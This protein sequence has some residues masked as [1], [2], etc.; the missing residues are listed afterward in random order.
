LQHHTDG[1]EEMETE[2]TGEATTSANAQAGD[3]GHANPKSHA[4]AWSSFAREGPLHNATY[5]KI[6]TFS[7]TVKNGSCVMAIRENLCSEWI[8]CMLSQLNYRFNK[9]RTMQKDELTKKGYKI[10]KIEGK[11]KFLFDL[12]TWMKGDG[13]KTVYVRP[14]QGKG[15]NCNLP[16]PVLPMADRLSPSAK[17]SHQTVEQFCIERYGMQ[18]DEYSEIV[19]GKV[20]RPVEAARFDFELAIFAFSRIYDQTRVSL[21]CP[22]EP[23]KS[24]WKIWDFERSKPGV[25]KVHLTFGNLGDR[26]Y[27]SLVDGADKHAYDGNADDDAI[28]LDTGV[29]ATGYEFEKCEVCQKIRLFPGKAVKQCQNSNM[30]FEG[31]PSGRNNNDGCKDAAILSMIRDFFSSPISRGQNAREKTDYILEFNDVQS[32]SDDENQ[33]KRVLNLTY[34]FFAI[35]AV[36]S[37]QVLQENRKMSRL[38]LML[39]V[40]VSHA[41][42]SLT[43]AYEDIFLK[44]QRGNNGGQTLEHFLQS[45]SEVRDAINEFRTE[46]LH[47]LDIREEPKYLLKLSA[48]QLVVPTT[49]PNLFRDRADAEQSEDLVRVMHELIRNTTIWLQDAE[50]STHLPGWKHAIETLLA[51][52]QFLIHSNEIRQNNLVMLGMNGIGKSFLMDILLRVSESDRTKYRMVFPDDEAESSLFA[53]ERFRLVVLAAERIAS[54]VAVNA[55]RQ[56]PV[57]NGGGMFG[58]GSVARQDEMD[59][60]LATDFHC[61]DFRLSQQE[62]TQANNLAECIT[63]DDIELELR[64]AKHIAESHAHASYSPKCDGN[65]TSFLLPWGRVSGSTTKCSISVRRAHRYQVVLEYRSQ[66]EIMLG[67]KQFQELEIK[68]ADRNLDRQSEEWKQ[69]DKKQNEIVKEVQEAKGL[70]V[71]DARAFLS[72][73]ISEDM[74]MLHPLLEV[75]SRGILCF[76][77]QGSSAL[78]DRMLIRSIV[79]HCQG[80]NDPVLAN[81]SPTEIFNLWKMDDGSANPCEVG[82]RTGFALKRITIFAPCELA[83]LRDSEWIDTAGSGDSNLIKKKVLADALQHASAVIALVSKNLETDGATID[84]LAQTS[85]MEAIMEQLLQTPNKIPQ[86]KVSVLINH[87]NSFRGGLPRAASLQDLKDDQSFQGKDAQGGKGSIETTNEALRGVAATVLRNRIPQVERNEELMILEHFEKTRPVS[88]IIPAPATAVSLIMTN[89]LPAA[90]RQAWLEETQVLELFGTV[91]V[92]LRGG[93]HT[94]LDEFLP[95]LQVNLARLKQLQTENAFEFTVPRHFLAEAQKRLQHK[96]KTDKIM[97]AFAAELDKT[98]E[99]FKNLSTSNLPAAFERCLRKKSHNTYIKLDM[100]SENGEM[101]T[102]TKRINDFTCRGSRLFKDVLKVQGKLPDG[103]LTAFAKTKVLRIFDH[104]SATSPGLN[105]Q[106]SSTARQDFVYDSLHGGFTEIISTA[107]DSICQSMVLELAKSGA[108]GLITIVNYN[109]EASNKFRREVEEHA[110][111]QFADNKDILIKMLVERVSAEVNDVIL[112]NAKA[113]L[114]ASL[115]GVSFK[116]LSDSATDYLLRY[117]CY[118]LQGL[119]GSIQK[120]LALTPALH[121]NR[122][123]TVMTAFDKFVCNLGIRQPPKRMPRSN[124]TMIWSIC[125]HIRCALWKPNAI[126]FL[127][128]HQI[129]ISSACADLEKLRLWLE[130]SKSC[131]RV[132][133]EGQNLKQIGRKLSDNFRRMRVMER[134]ADDLPGAQA[135]LPAEAN[136]DY[137]DFTERYQGGGAKGYIPYHPE[138]HARPIKE[139]DI[140]EVSESMKFLRHLNHLSCDF[141]DSLKAVVRDPSVHSPNVLLSWYCQYVLGMGEKDSANPVVT[142]QLRKRIQWQALES[143][144]TSFPNGTDFHDLNDF[145]ERI[146]HEDTYPDFLSLALLAC[147][148]QRAIN[149][150]VPWDAEKPFRISPFLYSGGKLS[151]ESTDGADGADA[152]AFIGYSTKG[153]KKV[154]L[155]V[156]CGKRNITQLTRSR[157]RLQHSNDGGDVGEKEA[158]EAPG[159]GEI[160][161]VEDD[162]QDLGNMDVTPGM[163]GSVSPVM[164]AGSLEH[165]DESDVSA[166][167]FATFAASEWQVYSSNGKRMYSRQDLTYGEENFMKLS[168]SYLQFSERFVFIRAKPSNTA[169]TRDAPLRNC[170]CLNGKYNLQCHHIPCD[171]AFAHGDNFMGVFDGVGQGRYP[172]GQFARVLAKQCISSS[173]EVTA[174]DIPNRSYEILRIAHEECITRFDHKFPGSS[175][176]SIV[177]LIKNKNDFELHCSWHGDSQIVVMGQG[178]D[179]KPKF[180]SVRAYIEGGRDS[181][182]PRLMKKGQIKEHGTSVKLKRDILGLKKGSKMEAISFDARG[183]M[184]HGKGGGVFVNASDLV[185]L[186]NPEPTQLRSRGSVDLHK[187]LHKMQVEDGDIVLLASDGLYDNILPDWHDKTKWNLE[188]DE[189]HE[190]RYAQEL[191]K[192]IAE[193]FKSCHKEFQSAPLNPQTTFV[194]HIGNKLC[195]LAMETMKT[196]SGHSDDLTVMISLINRGQP[197]TEHVPFT[198]M[199]TSKKIKREVLCKEMKEGKGMYCTSFPRIVERAGTVTSASVAAQMGRGLS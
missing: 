7:A 157:S 193:I 12:A 35:H 181:L 194:Q 59:D 116:Q 147:Y 27:V 81:K 146:T 50:G 10:D 53:K 110:T 11:G 120:Q 66:S 190:E 184:I 129:Q 108:E 118:V 176:A 173:R 199:F 125:D 145:S 152:I 74:Q 48:P 113:E 131:F 5:K 33:K 185:P 101:D 170:P 159:A 20:V 52:A 111:E 137:A 68:L 43:K 6:A 92:F 80:I 133:T 17:V 28:Q 158:D 196:E 141:T 142:M 103:P 130:K 13:K 167:T 26:Q 138:H 42:A 112:E 124:K 136:S 121:Q 16:P 87:E 79:H 106:V 58:N 38:G 51:K 161:R 197:K 34:F 1:N 107:M 177:S 89:S 41:K 30:Q 63:S 86:A 105:S 24:M 82:Q 189:E 85:A 18:I 139:C 149:V 119:I 60:D 148:H 164:P 65:S 76:V 153:L 56:A 54:E 25:S 182:T 134:I 172:S 154:P 165:V 180:V 69:Y 166:Y 163:S 94:V 96:A 2:E 78:H 90:H 3:I 171:D 175:T 174:G 84:A 127:E 19:V 155:F 61:E 143:L 67:W 40:R 191:G 21:L 179:Y 91:E 15:I 140:R 36:G 150:Y 71:K 109:P 32:P 31:M 102:I 23:R 49:L 72:N 195:G 9:M 8:D 144:H 160:D 95:C 169:I 198:N 126:S 70:T 4:H 128:S 188:T 186:Y 44:P 77:G 97:D 151:A 168:D 39:G 123:N 57:G 83:P 132:A 114:L 64:H 156:P 88:I 183:W 29:S 115:D 93:T 117:L 135:A 104:S 73:F 187:M 122:R 178:P 100:D 62:N 47:N 37:I 98:F 45:K 75:V 162:T 192:K 55:T 99:S 46:I 22:Q 14:Y